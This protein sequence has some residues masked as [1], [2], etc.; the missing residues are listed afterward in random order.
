MFEVCFEGFEAGFRCLK[1]VLGGFEAC[2]GGFEACFGG[3]IR[4]LMCFEV[5]FDGREAGLRC[6]F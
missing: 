3:L 1:F 6:L 2:F 4:V 5:C